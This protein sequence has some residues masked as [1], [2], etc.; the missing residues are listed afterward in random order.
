MRPNRARPTA[1]GVYSGANAETASRVPA[2]SF[3][4]RATAPRPP[5]PYDRSYMNPIRTAAAALLLAAWPVHAQDPVPVVTLQE[6][7]DAALRH[8]PQA[9]AA[10][11]A[12]QAAR[13]QSLLNAGAW[14]PT[15]T[16]NSTYGNSSNQRFDQST[17]TLVSQSYSMQ[18]ITGYEL[19]DGGRRLAE[20]RSA[21]AAV[22]AAEAGGVEQRFRILLEVK[23]VFFD[24]AAAA[25]LLGAARQRQD[26]A[27]RQA[28]FARTRLEIGTATRSDALRAELELGNAELAVVETERSL[29]SARQQLG[30]RMG[31]GGEVQPAAGSLP[32]TAP[33]LPDAETLAARAEAGSPAARAAQARYAASRATRTAAYT[34]Y[35]PS[36]R[37]TFG[38]DWVAPEFPPRD[39]DWSLRLTA[40]LPLFN[41]FQREA[42]VTRARATAQVAE[43]RARDARINVRVTPRTRRRELSSA[44]RRVEISQRAVE[45]AREDLRVQEERYQIGNATILD[46]Q[47]SQV[48]LAEAEV[49]AVRARQ[50]LGTAVGRLEAVLGM[51]LED[52]D[53]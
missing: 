52:L 43:A 9:V 2:L 12:M 42:A 49:A 26:R 53:I 28:E 22:R 45:L 1:C 7:L 3:A 38:Y 50:A 10:D 46:L 34:A 16:L 17:G 11:A 23:Q 44:E 40:S 19:F 4:R 48:A 30:R 14:L 41:G 13:A 39:R 33:A 18:V 6:A 31:V 5:E 20:G 36:L 51:N 21:S 47:T 15:L 29:R 8:D 25:E 27:E 24:A 35:A 32:T 37:A